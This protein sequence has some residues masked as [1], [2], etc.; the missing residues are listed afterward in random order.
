[1]TIS[2]L[3]SPKFVEDYKKLQ[4]RIESVVNENI[5]N[6]LYGLLKE[7]RNQVGYIDRCHEQMMISGK[8]SSELSE[9]REEVS[10]VRKALENKL[11]LH[12]KH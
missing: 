1:M 9:I 11:S 12:E 2:L 6:E 4:T 8:I 3:R 10:R 7:L 5:K